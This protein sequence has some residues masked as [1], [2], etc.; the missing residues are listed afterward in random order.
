MGRVRWLHELRLNLGPQNSSNWGKLTLACDASL[1]YITYNAVQIV[2]D[3]I[4]D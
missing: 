4:G 2:G 1:P 3:D